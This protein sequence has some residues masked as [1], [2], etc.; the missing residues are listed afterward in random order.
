MRNI[1]ISFL[2][3]ILVEMEERFGGTHQ[4]I[5]GLI[6]LVSVASI[7]DVGKVYECDLPSLHLLTL[8]FRGW[9]TKF[10]CST[11]GSQPKSLHEALQFCDK[12]SFSTIIQPL[13]I[14]C[15]LL[16]TVCENE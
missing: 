12:D 5:I 1:M 3:S 9:K 13:L 7:D 11:S 14:V 8:E 10:V 15:T 2:D 4:K 16:V 6:L